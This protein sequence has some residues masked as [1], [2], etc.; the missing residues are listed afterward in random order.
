ME[1][2]GAR[3]VSPA[4]WIGCVTLADL[5]LGRMLLRADE[6][7]VFFA[8]RALDWKCGF[9]TAAGL[10]CPTCGLTRSVVMS[11]HGEFVRAW[12]LAPGGP[13]LVIG[14]AALALA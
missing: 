3:T 2:K 6:T 10:P 5:A 12:H 1:A 11:L 8:G 9:H 4:F 7:R 13:A 14:L